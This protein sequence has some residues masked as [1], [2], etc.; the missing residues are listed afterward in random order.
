M[1][2]ILSSENKNK[3]VDAMYV[4]DAKEHFWKLWKKRNGQIPLA[5]GRK[6]SDSIINNN[7]IKNG[8]N[9]MIKLLA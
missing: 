4:T 2:D 5:T 7:M 6:K 8:S 1:L 3:I 9:L